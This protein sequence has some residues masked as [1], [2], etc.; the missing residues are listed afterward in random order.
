MSNIKRALCERCSEQ[1]AGL[2]GLCGFCRDECDEEPH[3]EYNRGEDE[4]LDDPRHGQAASINRER[5]I[6]GRD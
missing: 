2:D 5:Y 3:D 6:P 1:F 4:R